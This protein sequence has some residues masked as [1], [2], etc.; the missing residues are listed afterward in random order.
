MNKNICSFLLFYVIHTDTNCFVVMLHS[1][2]LL[3]H[4]GS[5]IFMYYKI[6][7]EVANGDVYFINKIKNYALLH[8]VKH[9]CA[10]NNA[11]TVLRAIIKSA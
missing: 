2:V 5:Q 8:K 10:I 7:L 3:S 9:V 1:F 6:A 4:C 11:I